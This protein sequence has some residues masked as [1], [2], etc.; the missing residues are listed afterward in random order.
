MEL[1]KE[2]QMKKFIFLLAVLSTLSVFAQQTKF[3]IGAEHVSAMRRFANTSLLP[4]LSNNFWDT[5]QSFGLN[6]VGLKYFQE[7][8][9][10]A[11]HTFGVV[12]LPNIIADLNKAASRNIAV[13]LTNGFDRDVATNVYYPKRWLYQVEKVSSNSLNDFA[14]VPTGQLLNENNPDPNQKV[15]SHWNLSPD[16]DNSAFNYLQMRLGNDPYGIVASNL[17]EKNLQPDSLNYYV[18][19]RMRLPSAPSFPHTRVLIIRVK[20]ASGSTSQDTVFADDLGNNNWKEIPVLSFY[21]LPGGPSIYDPSAS[22][23]N[24][25]NFTDPNGTVQVQNYSI[26]PGKLLT[27]YDIEIEWCSTGY[28]VDIDYVTIDDETANT[29]YT[30]GFDARIN[31]FADNYKTHSAMANF[32]IWDEPYIE[33][34]YPINKMQTMLNSRGVGNKYPISY[35]YYATMPTKRYLHESGIAINMPDI[36]PF[37]YNAPLPGDANYLTDAQSRLQTELVYRLS[38]AITNSKAFNK[39]FWY[40]TQ[41]HRWIRTGEMFCREPSVYETKAMANLGVCYGAKGIIYYLYSHVASDTTHI[42]SLYYDDTD[43]PRYFDTYGYPK[44]QTL[45]ELNQKLAAMGNVILS[46]TWQGAKSWHNADSVGTWNSYVRAIDAKSGGVSDNPDYV[47]TGHFKNSDT[48]FV[49]IVNRRTLNTDTR[50]ITIALANSGYSWITDVYTNKKWIVNTNGTFTD[51]FAPGEGKLYK[52]SPMSYNW[53]GDITVINTVTVASGTTLTV[54]SGTTLKFAPG[55]GL[56]M[57]GKLIVNGPVT[58]TT[59]S[60]TG[61]YGSWGSIILSG[62]GANNSTINYATIQYANEINI[63]S[64]SDVQIQNSTISNTINGIN[65][66]SSIGTISYNTLSYQ[67]DH[68]IIANNSNLTCRDNLITKTDHSGA[69]MLFTSGANSTSVSRNDISGYNWGIAS[70]WGATTRLGISPPKNNRVTNCLYGLYVYQSSSLTMCDIPYGYNS[71][72]NNTYYNAYV[73][74]SSS[75]YAYLNYWGWPVPTSKFYC[76][77]GSYLDYLGGPLQTDPWQPQQLMIAGNSS[78]GNQNISIAKSTNGAVVSEASTNDPLVNARK[79]REVGKEQEA[80]DILKPLFA[81]NESRTEAILELYSLHKEPFATEIENILSSLPV[82]T[83]P[84]GK[85]LHGQI[86]LR[87][88]E[89]ELALKALEG[90]SGTSFENAGNLAQF[91]IYLYK[92]NNYKQAKLLLSGLKAENKD[93]EL[94]LSLAQHALD[95]YSE[96]DNAQQ[97]IFQKKSG[98]QVTATTPTAFELS[99]NYPNPFNPTTTISFSLSEATNVRLAVYDYLGREIAILVDSFTSKG[100]HEVAFDAS[101][102]SSGIYFYKI[103][104]RKNIATKKMLLLK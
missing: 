84:L 25:Y 78:G 51:T 88:G 77:S 6:Y 42:T 15:L 45:K 79:L 33:N 96:A 17:R 14:N 89:S 82:K 76:Q 72:S 30:G 4:P 12:P 47:E 83:A 65:A 97:Q 31:D 28:A 60:G 101:K 61:T 34:H 26:K 39:P 22:E 46:L 71:V 44:W 66:F 62:T 35:R 74:S 40:A 59:P 85:Y 52:I 100:K 3:I 75:V 94:E 29:L 50:D 37:A 102:L 32:V 36:Y 57:N 24:I 81:S 99:Q 9:V 43:R 69:A 49:Y 95:T 16:L 58:F 27:G 19:I 13:Y 87:K 67:R 1:R 92:N 93:E 10:S 63:N 20:Q 18:R 5:V 54:N 2:Y 68:G 7:F 56:T 91:Y 73:Y 21:K 103:I 98:E 23:S 64:V 8:P 38:D 70:S 53:N 86:L 90:L 41:A 80:F 48:N 104:S 55:Q 11:P